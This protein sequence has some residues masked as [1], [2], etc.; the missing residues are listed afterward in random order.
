ME[1]R[2]VT[3]TAE[4]IV[5]GRRI[6]ASGICCVALIAGVAGLAWVARDE[7][8]AVYLLGF[9]H[10]VLYWLAYRY[11]AVPPAVFRRDAI[12]LKAISLST[13]AWVYLQVPLNLASLAV[14][15]GGFALNALAAKVLGAERTYY[16]YE[17]ASLPPVRI[18]SFPYSLI[19][20][21]MLVGNVIAYGGTLLNEAFRRQWWPLACLHIACNVGLLLMESC[22]EPLGRRAPAAREQPARDGRDSLFGLAAPWVAAGTIAV[23]VAVWAT[24]RTGVALGIAIGLAVTTCAVVFFRTYAQARCRGGRALGIVP[25]DME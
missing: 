4:Q 25:E 1:W 2:L 23:A 21:P 12:V 13:L 16:G 18:T 9:W 10:Y 19:S 3:A 17:V 15:S 14:I 11:G 7:A 5:V 6:D 20:H 8:V 22:V 24:T